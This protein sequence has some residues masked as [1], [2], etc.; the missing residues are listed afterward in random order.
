MALPFRI[1]FESLVTS[2]V[3][4]DT[5]VTVTANGK[6]EAFDWILLTNKWV[7][8]E[9]AFID[10]RSDETALFQNMESSEL[11]TSLVS[12][13]TG[14]WNGGPDF[15]LY[16]LNALYNW[17]DTSDR[18]TY[19]CWNN[20]PIRNPGDTSLTDARVCPQYYY[21]GIV[22]TEAAR[23]AELNNF[24]FA[25]SKVPITA[26]NITT[27]YE[28]T[29]NMYWQRKNPASF[30]DGYLW[31][32]WALQGKYRTWYLGSAITGIETFCDMVDYA[33]QI[34]AV[35]VPRPADAPAP[36]PAP[37]PQPGPPTEPEPAP[38]TNSATSTV[39]LFSW[40]TLLLAFIH[41]F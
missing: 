8:G 13:P 22:P 33:K 5:G 26:A 6:T 17:T 29:T 36:Q 32:A 9:S 24:L 19:G 35:M 4:S 2:V 10:L 27:V 39:S 25:I 28:F 1:R 41:K 37:V 15:I 12:V 16:N 18:W 20:L 38:T 11:R 31:D 40:F 7:K 30:S 14:V 34:T 3:R 23:K 21:N